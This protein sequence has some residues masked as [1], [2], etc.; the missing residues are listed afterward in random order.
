MFSVDSATYDIIDYDQYRLDIAKYNLLGPL[1]DKLEWDLFYSFKAEY[2]L[3]DVSLGSLRNL[4]ENLA[5]NNDVYNL[6][7]RNYNT[8]SN[9]SV[10]YSYSN[11]LYCA[12]TIPL[13]EELAACR[14]VQA[15]SS[16]ETK[17]FH[18]IDN[19]W[20]R[21]IPIPEWNTLYK[22][23]QKRKKKTILQG[24]GRGIYFE[25]HLT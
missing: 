4:A 22:K 5:S 21:R 11:A 14:G 9:S 19:V 13:L 23:I 8:Q 17:I 20:T 7:Q 24:N 1:A 12:T 16:N 10:T 25:K 6:M 2:N 18:A 15:Y 3:T